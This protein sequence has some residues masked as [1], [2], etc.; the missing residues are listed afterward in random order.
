MYDADGNYLGQRGWVKP[1][2]TYAA[3]EL[4]LD[5]AWDEKWSMNAS[6]TMSWNRGN[7][8]G[9]VNSDT[10]FDDTGRT[11][12]FD[13]PWV[14]LGGDGYLPND[15]RHQFK[16]RGTYALTPHWQIGANAD[17][18]SGGPITG[19]GVG[20]PYDATNYHS[21]YT[22]VQNCDSDVSSERVYEHSARGAYGRMPWTYTL[23]A[24]LS[25]ILPFEG[26]GRM[27]VKLAVYNLLNQQRTVQVDQTLQ[28]AISNDTDATFRLPT[29]FQAPRFTQLTFAVDF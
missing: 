8:E 1:K 11:E 20:N 5:R 15:R 4:Q 22:C 18:R 23:D 6:Y 21:Y 28:S 17:V 9:P 19:F 12:N 2:R 27:R 3:V 26:R 13:D 16:L 14:N 25:Y 10:D 7:A 24:S 29:G